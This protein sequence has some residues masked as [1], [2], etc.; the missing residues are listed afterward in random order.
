MIYR[1]DGKM[2]RARARVKKKKLEKETCDSHMES[3]CG[4]AASMAPI[5]GCSS[6]EWVLSFSSVNIFLLVV[7]LCQEVFRES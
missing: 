3:E 6:F 4:R 1:A 7:C 5:G 2:E